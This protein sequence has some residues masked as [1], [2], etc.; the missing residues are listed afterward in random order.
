MSAK[1][2]LIDPLATNRITL[3][4]K[5]RRAHYNVTSVSCVDEL[6]QD[7]GDLHWDL[8]VTG[9]QDSMQVDQ[10]RTDRR[11]GK[12]PL[13]AVYDQDIPFDRLT[14]LKAGA[15]DVLC[16]PVSEKMLLAK[17]RSL[18]RMSHAAKELRL[19]EDTNRILGFNEAPTG[20]EIR[21][22]CIVISDIPETQ[23]ILGPKLSRI[24]NLT[25]QWMTRNEFHTTGAENIVTDCYILCVNTGSPRSS[26]NQLLEMRTNLE[27]RHS[28]I[29]VAARADATQAAMD[30]LDLGAND[31]LLDSFSADEIEHRLR[32]Q[33]RHKKTND[34]LRA[35][36]QAGLDAALSDP[37][38]GLYN[39]RY[40]MTHL[41]HCVDNALTLKSDLAVILVDLD[42]F[43]VINDT[44][45]HNV[46]DQ[47]LTSVATR[48]K[49]A[50]R[51]SDMIARIG[52]EEFMIILVDTP[53]DIA[54]TLADR[55]CDVI[56]NTALP[57][58]THPITASMG[59]R[60]L[61]RNARAATPDDLFRQADSA[62]YK[63]KSN[64]RNQVA[65]Y[66]APPPLPCDSANSDSA[67][68]PKYLP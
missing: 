16:K 21:Q 15:D 38:T 12:L 25:F 52:G 26:I 13:I 45:G 58:I 41:S 56:A 1:I 5:L 66:D 60:S 2:L 32:A 51:A 59:L 39:R 64:G 46:G 62:L 10:I 61:A 24:R 48:L 68:Q 57:D 20:F 8:V 53:P 67:A 36:V 40:A 31:V 18:L 3:G 28:A 17:I 33:I 6:M 9:A 27:T 44:Y 35:S 54:R 11:I 50:V 63:A 7:F 37:L 14:L 30:S 4:F 22:K 29:L 47:V 19:R 43:K 55:L 42:H 65:A 23:N 34:R 49:G